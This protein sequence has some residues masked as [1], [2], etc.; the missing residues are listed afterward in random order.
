[1]PTDFNTKPPIFFRG[2]CL[3]S[4]KNNFITYSKSNTFAIISAKFL[5]WNKGIKAVSTLSWLFHT[6]LALKEF[7]IIKVKFKQDFYSS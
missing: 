4:L 3:F 7:I 5:L 6:F 2:L 1:M